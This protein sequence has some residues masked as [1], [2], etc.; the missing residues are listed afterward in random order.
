MSAPLG[1]KA[2]PSKYDVYQDLP[3]DEPYFVIRAPAP[4]I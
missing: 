1:S 4:P 3:E 2:N